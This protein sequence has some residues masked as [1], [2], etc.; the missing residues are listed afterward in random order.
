MMYKLS[1]Q[2]TRTVELPRLRKYGMRLSE[3]KGNAG[4]EGVSAELKEHV[5]EAHAVAV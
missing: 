2:L 1:P 3:L 5:E 4:L